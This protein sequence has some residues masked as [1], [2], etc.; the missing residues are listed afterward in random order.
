MIGVLSAQF[1]VNYVYRIPIPAA[2]TVREARER[3]GTSLSLTDMCNIGKTNLLKKFS[4]PWL[5]DRDVPPWM[6]KRKLL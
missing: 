5:L 4:L 1:H 3:V 2:E 6:F